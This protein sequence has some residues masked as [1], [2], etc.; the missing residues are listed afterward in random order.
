MVRAKYTVQK[1]G[2]YLDQ[3]LRVP[4]DAAVDEA[5]G[6]LQTAESF[7]LNPTPSFGES[8]EFGRTASYVQSAGK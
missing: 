7:N 8:H 3:R 2:Q 6:Y 5:W 4:D 1:G